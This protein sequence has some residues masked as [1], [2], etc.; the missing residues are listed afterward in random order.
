[1]VR[2]PTKKLRMKKAY[3]KYKLCI[4]LC[5]KVTLIAISKEMREYWLRKGA[6]TK[7]VSNRSFKLAWDLRYPGRANNGKSCY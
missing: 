4:K 3:T 7:R 5:T 2:K 1:M 6:A